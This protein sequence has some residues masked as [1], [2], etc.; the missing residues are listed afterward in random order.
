MCVSILDV[1][2]SVVELS[3]IAPEGFNTTLYVSWRTPADDGRVVSQYYVIVTNYSN[4]FVDAKTVPGDM[5]STIVTDL[6]E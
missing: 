5:T 1:P 4:I 2:G 6:G 3:A